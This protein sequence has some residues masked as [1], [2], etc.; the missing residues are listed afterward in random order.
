MRYFFLVRSTY[1]WNEVTAKT[2]EG[3][4]TTVTSPH[5]HRN[6]YHNSI[7][8]KGPFTETFQSFTHQEP[9]T[10]VEPRT[11]I[12]LRKGTSRPYHGGSLKMTGWKS[13]GLPQIASC[14]QRGGRHMVTRAVS[15]HSF[16]P[17]RA[18]ACS[19]ARK[20]AQKMPSP[21]ALASHATEMPQIHPAYSNKTHSTEFE[22][23]GCR[24]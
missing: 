16:C 7:V 20:M 15:E 23:V 6:L 13:S 24:L 22:T 18:G 11:H 12:L 5:L 3:K 17:S 8:L 14:G 21:G 9:T 2:W 10:S 4:V 1:H 19:E